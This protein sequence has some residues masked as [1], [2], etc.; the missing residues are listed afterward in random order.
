MGQSS[1]SSGMDPALQGRQGRPCA[2]G[3][4]RGAGQ[5][6]A[7]YVRQGALG[8]R[9]EER[10]PVP[11]RSGR[12]QRGLCHAARRHPHHFRLRHELPRRD[13]GLDLHGGHAPDQSHGGPHHTGDLQRPSRRQVQRRR[14]ARHRRL[15]S[16]RVLACLGARSRHDH[17][18]LRPRL[19]R[20]GLGR[21][22][23]RETA[24]RLERRAG[25]RRPGSRRRRR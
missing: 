16:R 9:Q 10:L 20:L 3:A 21:A 15:R 6:A 7:K 18:P 4:L 12:A 11:R 14:H 25:S 1:R 24:P 2:G 23:S 22:G 8:L 13:P 17:R 19:E 5:A